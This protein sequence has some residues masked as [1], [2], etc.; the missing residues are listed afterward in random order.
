M[1]RL[2]RILAKSLEK[3]SLA[4]NNPVKKGSLKY[5]K[6]LINIPLNPPLS[7][8]LTTFPLAILFPRFHLAQIGAQSLASLNRV[9]HRGSLSPQER[10][11]ANPPLHK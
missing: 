3:Y 11:K 5:V 9:K 8:L 6:A 2:V 10:D 7:N 4:L 1:Q